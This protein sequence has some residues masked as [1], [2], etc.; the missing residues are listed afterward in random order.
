MICKNCNSEMPNDCIYCANCG[1]KLEKEATTNNQE[2]IKSSENPKNNKKL[3]A[4][5]LSISAIII[6]LLIAIIIILTGKSKN[7]NS[8][9]KVQ[10]TSE[11]TQGTTTETLSKNENSDENNTDDEHDGNYAYESDYLYPTVDEYIAMLNNSDIV[12]VGANYEIEYLNDNPNCFTAKLKY[13]NLTIQTVEA[14]SPKS[15]DD[16]NFGRITNVMAVTKNFAKSSNQNQNST[17]LFA[18]AM[19]PIMPILAPNESVSYALTIL[20]N[21]TKEYW[22]KSNLHI[23]TGTQNDI[24]WAVIFT[25][26]GTIAT[27]CGELSVEYLTKSFQ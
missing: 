12:K 5:V 19:T 4:V 8:S 26:D 6:I 14:G 11:Q 9:T 22:S 20:N 2:L 1:T 21:H 25:S 16:D 23:Y 13:E 10:T 24:P 27:A 7:I 18:T 17:V 3:F 15:E